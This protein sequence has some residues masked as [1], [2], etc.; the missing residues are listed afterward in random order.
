[1]EKQNEKKNEIKEKVKMKIKEKRKKRT[2][3]WSTTQHIRKHRKKG[4]ETPTSGC[5]CAHP[6]EPPSVSRDLR[7]YRLEVPTKADIAQLPV[8]LTFN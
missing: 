7:H 4:R 6:R 8:A 3:T 2:R 5:A 1:M